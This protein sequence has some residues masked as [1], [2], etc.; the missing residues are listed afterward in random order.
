[1]RIGTYDRSKEKEER[2]GEAV[3][4][5]SCRWRGTG[6]AVVVGG[7]ECSVIRPL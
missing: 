7:S 3:E 6:L 1:M 4:V 5:S 2:K